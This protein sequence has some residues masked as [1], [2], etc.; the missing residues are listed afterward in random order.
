VTVSSPP[1]AA[2][3]DEAGEAGVLAGASGWAGV[4]CDAD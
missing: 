2:G 3:A 4:V 1:T